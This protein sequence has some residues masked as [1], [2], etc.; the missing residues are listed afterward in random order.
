M[1]VLSIKTLPEPVLRQKTKKV[2]SIDASIKKLVA[3]MQE[4]LHADSGRLGLAAPQI[5]VS[6]RVAV[7][8][9]PELAE[10]GIKRLAV[11]CPSFVADCLETLEEIGIR[12]REQWH[13]L[14]GEEL[15]AI[16]C[17]NAHPSFAKGVASWI[18]ERAA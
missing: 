16:P 4:T 6:L 9:L 17:V 18:R 13:A 14:G 7:I 12:A 1:A 10:R 8:S 5:G 3:D 11:I 15:L 2:A